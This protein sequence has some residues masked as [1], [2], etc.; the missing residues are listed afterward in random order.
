MMIQRYESAVCNY[1]GIGMAIALCTI[2]AAAKPAIAQDAEPPEQDTPSNAASDASDDE[3]ERQ[4]INCM[5]TATPDYID[6]G[7]RY[8]YW[9]SGVAEFDA[10]GAMLPVSN[11]HAGDWILTLTHS[12]LPSL[13]T[14]NVFPIRDEQA[15]PR[16][17]FPA[18]TAQEREILG[19]QPAGDYVSVFSY[20]EATYGLFLGIRNTEA[21]DSP[22]QLFQVIHFLSEDYAMISNVS[23]CFVGP[24]PMVIG[25]L[26][27]L[28]L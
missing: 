8:T 7:H 18:V 2:V 26:E 28:Y 14:H 22:R 20:N 21:V 19:G 24:R 6:W 13:E 25:A 4:V 3:P 9:L 12:L 15:I 17:S 10:S 1:V 16:F 23:A 5:A 27:S 11:D